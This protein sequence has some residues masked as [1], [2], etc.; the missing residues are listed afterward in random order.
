MMQEWGMGAECGPLGLLVWPQDPPQAMPTLH[1]PSSQGLPLTI[2]FLSTF[3][4]LKC[5]VELQMLLACS[6]FLWGM[7]AEGFVGRN[8]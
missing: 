3:A 1:I 6:E 7:E 8:F 2:P 4:W 5:A